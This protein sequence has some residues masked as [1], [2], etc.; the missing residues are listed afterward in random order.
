[1]NPLKTLNLCNSISSRLKAVL[2]F[3]NNLR[4]LIFKFLSSRLNIRPYNRLDKE[5]I[6]FKECKEGLAM[7]YNT[8]CFH[9][10]AEIS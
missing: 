2:Y 5:V 9:L 4:Q 3:S 1:M 7:L 8:K 6:D 10:E